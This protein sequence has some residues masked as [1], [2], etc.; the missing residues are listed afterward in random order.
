METGSPKSGM[1]PMVWVATIAVTAFSAIGIASLTGLLPQHKTD[2]KPVEVV[3]APVAATPAAEPPVATPPPAPAV[4][5]EAP[6][7]AAKPIAKPVQR[8]PA[9]VVQHNAPISNNAPP[10]PAVYSTAPPVC[11]SCGVIE[12][13]RTVA[14]EGEGSG[15]GA[16]AGGVVGGLLGNGVGQGRGR[17]VATVAG[18]VGGAFLGNKLEKDQKKSVTYETVV[19]Y[20]NG[21]HVT[22]PSEAAPPWREGDRVRVENGHITPR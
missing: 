1:H 5:E 15:L 13:V 20:E 21:D 18:L 22:I 6:K 10:P 19:R 11:N 9:K 2:D 7:P 17:D 14:R 8:A 12:A 3:S 4:A 16:V